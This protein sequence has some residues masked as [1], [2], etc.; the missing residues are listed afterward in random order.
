MLALLAKSRYKAAASINIYVSD[1]LSYNTCSKVDPNANNDFPVR[2]PSTEG[3]F[4]RPLPFITA[5]AVCF[6]SDKVRAGT[7]EGDENSDHIKHSDSFGAVSCVKY[8]ESAEANPRNKKIA[9][10]NTPHQRISA[11]F[12][13]S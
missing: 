13:K 2:S 7:E 4:T 5:F 3:I 12:R 6:M 8:Y 10:V 1:A 9:R 11:P